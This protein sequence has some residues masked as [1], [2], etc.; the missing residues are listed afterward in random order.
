MKKSPFIIALF[1]LFSCTSQ[2]NNNQY[3]S[4]QEAIR[5]VM[6]M[7]EKAWNRGDLET[8]MQGYWKN[9]SPSGYF[10]LIWKKIDGKWYIITDMTCG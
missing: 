7:Q 10:N 2:K 1:L 4:P 5:N 9:D 6:K 3:I 8:F